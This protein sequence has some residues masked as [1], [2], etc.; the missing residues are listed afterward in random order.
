MEL[1]KN[2][3][4]FK[5]RLA[6]N[7]YNLLFN[8]EQPQKN[9]LFRPGRMAFLWDL[10]DELGNWETPTTLIRSKAELRSDEVVF[11]FLTTVFP[12]SG[13]FI[14]TGLFWTYFETFWDFRVS[15]KT[16][17]TKLYWKS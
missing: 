6:K 4:E 11:F 3:V 12:R 8:H 15:R 16:W 17:I 2:V 7:V 14:L 9:Q 5:T 10:D 13:Q 1:E